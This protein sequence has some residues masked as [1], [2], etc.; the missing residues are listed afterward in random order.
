MAC[1]ITN[2]KKAFE[3]SLKR[4]D[5]KLLTMKVTHE[6]EDLEATKANAEKGLEIIGRKDFGVKDIQSVDRS[7]LLNNVATVLL[8]R[9]LTDSFQAAISTV[10][11]SKSKRSTFVLKTAEYKNGSITL[12]VS[13][14][15]QD[16]YWKYVFD[17]DSN[18]SVNTVNGN[19]LFIPG[20]NQVYDT[21]TKQVGNLQAKTYTQAIAE[22]HRKHVDSVQ[23]LM[24]EDV[25]LEEAMTRA[26]SYG[27]GKFDYKKATEVEGYDHENIQHMR[28]MLM[29]LHAVSGNSVD[30]ETFTHY[31]KL[32]DAM[33]PHFFRKMKLFINENEDHTQGWVDID[34]EHI[35]LNTSSKTHN[36]MSN[37]EVY[38]HETI[39]TMTLWALEKKDLPEVKKLKNRLN[40]LMK[41]ARS[42][43]TWQSLHKAD[44]TIS[45]EAA[46]ERYDYIF[47]SPNAN[48]EFIAHGT[49]NPGFM[50]A[51]AGVRLKDERGKG[52]LNAIKDFFSDL[53][54]AVMGNYQFTHKNA[55]LS[56]EIHALAFRLAE[57]N[58]KAADKVVSGNVFSNI[59]DFVTKIEGNFEELVHNL[60]GKV[61]SVSNVKL[62]D[63]MTHMQ[64]VVF[65]G[66]TLIKSLYNKN[67]R[68]ALGKMFSDYGIETDSSIREVVRSVIPKLD[69]DMSVQFLGL[70]TSS[71][72]ALRNLRV[73][74][75]ATSITDG[76]TKQ[77]AE[78]EEESL[79]SG[80]VETN[81]TT[82]FTKARNS[83]K[84]YSKDQL[85]KLFLDE[86]YRKR[87]IG[88]LGQKIRK[89]SPDRANWLIG[90]SEGLGSF[91]VTGQGHEA[92][93]VNSRNIAV[94][95][96]TSEMFE[97]DAYLFNLVEE[98]VA[99]NALDKQDSAKVLTVGNLLK[100]EETGV[101]NVVNIYE[102]FK[103][104]SKKVFIGDA[105][106]MMEGYTRELFDDSI[107]VRYEAL[108][109]EAEMEKQGYT[110][111]STI[112]N[113]GL[114][115]GTE[116]GFYVSA[117]HFK[118]E[119][120]EGAV[121]LGSLNSRGLTLKEARFKQFGGEGRHAHVWFENDKMRM[122]KK[123]ID[124]HARLN[125]GEK[126]SDIEMGAIPIVDASNNI[127]DYRTTMLKDSKRRYLKQTMGITQVLSRTMGTLVDKMAREDHNNSALEVIKA[128]VKNV[129]DKAGEDDL[130]QYTLV[131]DKST[132]PAIRQ[133]FY[134]LP[135][136]YQDFARNRVDESLP[137]PS[138]LMQQY[139]GYAHARTSNLPGINR[140]P[141]TI[142]R[143]IDM[144]EGLY[145]D[146]VKLAKGNI[147]LKM[148]VVLVGN[149][150]SNIM[151]AFN[152]GMNPAEIFTA[153]RDSF[154]DVKLFMANQKE[155]EK[156]KVELMGLTQGYNT[157]VFKNEK[158]RSDYS[159]Q[160]KRLKDGMARLV[161][162]MDE[163][164]VKELFDLGM[165]QSVIEDISMY[166]LGDTNS[167]SDGMDKLLSKVP[168]A[169]KLPLQ[170]A[171]LSKETA[172]YK[173]NQEVLQLSDLVARDVM[174]RKQK[175]IE[176]E[177]ANGTRDLPLEYRKLMGKGS[178]VRV[179]TPL[180][181][182][183]RANFMELAKRS[184]QANLLNSFVNYNLPN[185][186]GEEYLNR[187]GTLMFTKY[188]KRIQNVITQS[189]IQHPIRTIVT[190]SAA[191][192][193]LDADVIQDQAFLVKGMDNNDAGLLGV[194]PLYTPLDVV[195]NVATPAIVKFH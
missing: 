157:T 51:I 111:V 79:T 154:R 89:H 105:S 17:S 14:K 59:S 126:F 134:M 55:L 187:T 24:S 21:V 96:G 91:M 133:L 38:M 143:I 44:G 62:P 87:T 184:R 71:I 82:L 106:H 120:L 45:E 100:K 19:R 73:G 31:N 80:L 151:Y 150:V 117:S 159:D 8:R 65:V 33:H 189:S 177:Q 114:A 194:L 131:S 77:L 149:I 13:P 48:D 40:Y 47:S 190:L 94:G 122:D 28:D 169:V 3:A 110:L 174:N 52:L 152:T 136:N 64:E 155:F 66:K 171:Y 192:F 180:K 116:L 36:G 179:L 46:K 4:A 183:E 76:F 15:G 147:L 83:G 165:Y 85:S 70:K 178:P 37:A 193:A 153:Y 109:A 140:L 27:E 42:N 132:D 103:V 25:T 141:A 72:G 84:G 112:S 119:R 182:D 29:D 139:F 68:Y 129:Y 61:D 18:K 128:N 191:A 93:N 43:T 86:G 16:K 127:V 92:Q 188:L 39:H 125:A 12:V 6:G 148:P 137:I 161:H 195:M 1:S 175:I 185:G 158:E 49:T 168:T 113:K 163:S 99:L 57:V 32:L 50:R 2:I 26:S 121:S 146:A 104:E 34:K 107:D 22:A 60:V 98:L 135:K 108:S 35:L 138:I 7:P 23:D 67:Y 145:M 9:E 181:G 11:N 90:Q 160:V 118:P 69:D 142:K 176:K 166:K 130:A 124:I 101:R 81:A 172:W 54:N 75:V 58:G 173:F 144:I 53:M 115:G 123:A 78:S 56:D 95:A 162:E 164:D 74:N 10:A 156:N 167:I 20:F 5:T 63:N 41:Q 88:R 30:N 170:W 186:K 102:D 97:Y